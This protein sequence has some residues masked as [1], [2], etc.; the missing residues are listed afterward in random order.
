MKRL[1]PE[2]IRKF[3]VVFSFPPGEGVR[4]RN[5]GGKGMLRRIE[6]KEGI[7]CPARR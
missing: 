2:M 7:V 1:H 3:W 5:V 6:M 4:M